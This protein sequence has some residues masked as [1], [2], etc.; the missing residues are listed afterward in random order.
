MNRRILLEEYVYTSL[1]WTKSTFQTLREKI[2]AETFAWVAVTIP[3]GMYRVFGI[4]YYRDL[5]INQSTIMTFPL[6]FILSR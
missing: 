4:F 5:N 2:Y 1:R 3:Q 6:Q